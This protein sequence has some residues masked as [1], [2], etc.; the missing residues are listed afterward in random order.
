[1]IIVNKLTKSYDSAYNGVF[2]MK[3]IKSK[4]LLIALAVMVAAIIITTI[5]ICVGKR[6][7]INNNNNNNDTGIELPIIDPN[8]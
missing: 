3:N 7:E 4:I 2:K 6:P 5:I 1:M 8:A